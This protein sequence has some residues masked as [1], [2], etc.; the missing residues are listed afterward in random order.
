MGISLEMWHKAE[1]LIA[2]D[3]L[4]A[5]RAKRRNKPYS[6]PQ[7]CHDLAAAMGRNDAEAVAAIMLYRFNV[8]S[9]EP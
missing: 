8:K 1:S 3:C 9:S 5:Y 2:A 6:V 7:R 4:S